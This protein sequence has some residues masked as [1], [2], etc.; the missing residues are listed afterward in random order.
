MNT[1][2]KSNIHIALGHLVDSF[3]EILKL[4]SFLFQF[5]DMFPSLIFLFR[6]NSNAEF[7]ILLATAHEG[8]IV[9]H[10]LPLDLTGEVIVCR[11]NYFGFYG[12]LACNLSFGFEVVLDAHDT[13]THDISESADK[14]TDKVFTVCILVSHLES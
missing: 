3:I 5:L 2:S 14:F 4:F 8:N 7:K 13:T 12:N 9:F 11:L 6:S 10:A 1:K